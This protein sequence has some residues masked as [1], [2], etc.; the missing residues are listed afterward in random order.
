MA[1]RKVLGHNDSMTL[2]EAVEKIVESL[3]ELGN[4]E[5]EIKE[6]LV[7]QFL[8]PCQNIN[9]KFIFKPFMDKLEED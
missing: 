7:D 9:G 3:P 5:K 6:I 8:D 1:K 4:K 2:N